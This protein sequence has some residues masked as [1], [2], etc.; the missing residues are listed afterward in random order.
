M[1]RSINAKNLILSSLLGSKGWNSLWVSFIY[2]LM[3]SSSVLA[4]VMLCDS[5]RVD[6][7]I[8][9]V[10][11][12]YLAVCVFFCFAMHTQLSLTM[13]KLNNVSTAFILRA[14]VCVSDTCFRCWMLLDSHQPISVTFP[15]LLFLQYSILILSAW[16]IEQKFAYTNR[17]E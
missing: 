11:A 9:C 17:I 14:C 1:Q 6:N 10:V 7:L 12:C 4:S 8:W 16:H 5:L 13:L 3:V 2:W 15:F